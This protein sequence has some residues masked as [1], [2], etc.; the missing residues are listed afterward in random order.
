MEKTIKN[1]PLNQIFIYRFG[2]DIYVN[3]SF[4]YRK[5]RQAVNNFLDANEFVDGDL[6]K[7]ETKFSTH[8][9]EDEDKMSIGEIS[10][11]LDD[12]YIVE[13]DLTPAELRTA[14]ALN[15]DVFLEMNLVFREREVNR[16]S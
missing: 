3:K 8:Q 10:I 5:V 7:D 1:T 12:T 6:S 9:T 2:E 14:D 13:F 15:K 4:L 11:P 16:K